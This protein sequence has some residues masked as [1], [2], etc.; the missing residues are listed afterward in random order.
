MKRE[1]PDWLFVCQKC[2]HVIYIKK[3]RIKELL[4]LECPECGEEARLLW[5]IS[6]EGDY[7]K[8]YG[9]SN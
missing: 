8:E 7:D 4:K 3:D 2:N 9:D 1:K 5:I 6:G